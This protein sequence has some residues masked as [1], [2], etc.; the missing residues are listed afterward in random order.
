MIL[1]KLNKELTECKTTSDICRIN[2]LL[3]Q[4]ILYIV[5]K[6][7][8]FLLDITYPWD[9]IDTTCNIDKGAL[10]V[11]KEPYIIEGFLSLKTIPM[12]EILTGTISI[13]EKEISFDD[14]ISYIQRTINLIPIL[15]D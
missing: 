14:R 6:G 15:E 13:S 1:E 10:V 2:A 11:A 9:W 5:D 8:Y 7:Y 3:C 12:S 4:I